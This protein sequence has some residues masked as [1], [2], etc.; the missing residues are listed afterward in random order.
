MTPQIIDYRPAILPSDE[1]VMSHEQP[2]QSDYLA[3]ADRP[4]S[5]QGRTEAMQA[6]IN[7]EMSPKFQ[8][9]VDTGTGTL[10]GPLSRD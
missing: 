5:D 4:V 1:R 6:V 8:H 10:Q 3:V 9:E 2:L 7:S